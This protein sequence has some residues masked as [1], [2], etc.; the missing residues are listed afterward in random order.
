MHL[1]YV[2]AAVCMHVL[3]RV[4]TQKKSTC[5]QKIRTY[6]LPNGSAWRERGVSVLEV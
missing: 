3:T 2:S 4:G 1:S 5:E 6:A